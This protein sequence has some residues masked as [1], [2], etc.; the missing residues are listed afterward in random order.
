MHQLMGAQELGSIPLAALL[1][2]RPP[3]PEPLP[4]WFV[5]PELRRGGWA[6]EEHVDVEEV[7]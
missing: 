2:E 3:A 5:P 4:L 6:S 1:A 7:R